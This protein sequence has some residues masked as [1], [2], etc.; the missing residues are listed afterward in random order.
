MKSEY[1]IIKDTREQ[2]GYYFT[3]YENCMGMIDKKL[4]TGDYT[5]EGLEDILCVERK[6][7]PEEIALNFGKNKTTF[8]K[9]VERMQSFKYKIMLLEFS[10][11]D[12]LGFPQNSSMPIKAK[13]ASKITGKYLLKFLLELQIKYNVSILFCGDKHNAFLV[14]CSIFKR[15]NEAEHR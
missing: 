12:V 2:Q 7:S 3:K 13:E 5:I 11:E 15:I 8:L 10:V 9:E 1:T 4:D 6:A 14:L